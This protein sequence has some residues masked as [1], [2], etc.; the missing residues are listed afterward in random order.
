[1]AQHA[2][3]IP[4]AFYERRGGG[5]DRLSGVEQLQRLVHALA[6]RVPLGGPLRDLGVQP[7]EVDEDRRPSPA[8]PTGRTAW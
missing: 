6:Q 1:M 3:G 8:A 2:E 7:V 4:Q 5:V